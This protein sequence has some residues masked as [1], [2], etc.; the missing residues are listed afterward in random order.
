[1]LRAVWWSLAI[2]LTW[3][4]LG[5]SNRP[6]PPMGE[7]LPVTPPAAEAAEAPEGEGVVWLEDYDAAVAQAK[8]SGRVL[9]VNVTTPWCKA[10]QYMDETVYSRMDI[11]EA[12]RALVLVRVNA[13]ERMD[14][15]QALGV[16][17]YPTVVFVSPGGEEAGRV[18]GVVPAGI[19]LEQM[20][21]AAARAEPA[22]ASEE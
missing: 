19:M 5:C 14:V 12:S 11:A 17:G 10:C 1:M 2:A 20:G 21:K 15:K 16:R 9:M 8:E 4:L 3:G 6:A 7:I 13:E 18:R 22:P